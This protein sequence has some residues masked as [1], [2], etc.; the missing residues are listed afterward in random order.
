MRTIRQPLVALA[1]LCA[2]VIAAP[3]EAIVIDSFDAG[4]QTIGPINAFSSPNPR[5][6]LYVGPGPIGNRREFR[7][8]E[9]HP[10]NGTTFTITGTPPGEN[11]IAWTG[12][13]GATAQWLRYGTRI[14]TAAPQQLNVDFSGETAIELDFLNL[15][16]GVPNPGPSDTTWFVQVW[17]TTKAGT[18]DEDTWSAF[19]ARVPFIGGP[20]TV[21]LPLADF[22]NGSSIAPT[23]ADLADVDGIE[24]FQGNNGNFQAGAP[25]RHVVLGEVRTAGNPDEDND[26]VVDTEDLCPGT[27]IPEATV[28]SRRLGTNR[29][30]LVDADGVFDTTQPKGRGPQKSFTIE[31]TAGCSCEQIIA[32]GELGEGHTK[33]GCS[34]SVMEEFV[35][36]VAP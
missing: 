27:M 3:A 31:E 21:S 4:P 6:N 9:G 19:D 28:P 14:V 13:F 17:L 29:W 10:T 32:I 16:G 35:D 25:D 23:A 30:A 20:I 11:S 22:R 33:F 12:P 5:T 26:G 1:I 7:A 8:G 34:I 15:A 24:V 36:A 2:L 18:V